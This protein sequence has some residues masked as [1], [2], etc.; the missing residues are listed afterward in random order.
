MVLHRRIIQSWERSHEVNAHQHR[1]ADPQI[2][3]TRR[4]SAF[5]APVQRSLWRSCFEGAARRCTSP[6]QRQ[7]WF[8]SSCCSPSITRPTA[9]RTALPCHAYRYGCCAPFAYFVL[10]VLNAPLSQCIACWV[11][12][13]VYT[14][15]TGCVLVYG[16]LV[17]F[18]GGWVRV[19][20]FPEHPSPG[21][22]GG[23]TWPLGF[24]PAAA[25]HGPGNLCSAYAAHPPG[26]GAEGSGPTPGISALL[27]AAGSGRYWYAFYLLLFIC[28]C[29]LDYWNLVHHV[30]C[31]FVQKWVRI[32]ACVVHFCCE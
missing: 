30:V 10:C 13:L 25:R 5:T 3:S 9:P 4:R 19:C 15:T 1:V 22:V 16:R 21:S 23:P 2:L 18:V 12:P 17:A 29:C 31:V 27:T 26:V 14:C 24:P 11:D 32:L 20:P 6:L 28:Y 7:G 8:R